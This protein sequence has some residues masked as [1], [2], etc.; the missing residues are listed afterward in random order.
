MSETL[1]AVNVLG[2]DDIYAAPDRETAERWAAWFSTRFPQRNEYDPKIEGV[3]IEWPNTPERH[4]EYLPQ[5]IA[6]MTRPDGTV[7]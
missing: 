1:W 2:P 3:V 5:C 6:G 4:A 7:V